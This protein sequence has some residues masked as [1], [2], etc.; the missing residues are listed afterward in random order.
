MIPNF[1]YVGLR[2]EIEADNRAL[3]CSPRL[4]YSRSIL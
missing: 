4:G 1:V 3:N 2:A